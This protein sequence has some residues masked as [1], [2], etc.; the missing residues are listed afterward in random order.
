MKITIGQRIAAAVLAHHL[1]ISA[2]R[3]FK[4]YIQGRDLDPTWEEVGET[5]LKSE[6][7]SAA[8][9][10]SSRPALG[11]R[12]V[13]SEFDSQPAAAGRSRKATLEKI[14]PRTERESEVS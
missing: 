10:G 1:G 8:T 5:L 14:N 9:L 12:L 4:I 2:D 3:A 11:P 7:A 6:R 13:R